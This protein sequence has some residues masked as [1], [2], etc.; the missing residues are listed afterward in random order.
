MSGSYS[1]YVQY[2]C[3]SVQTTSFVQLMK[4]ILE[5]FDVIDVGEE[6]F[7]IWEECLSVVGKDLIHHQL[8]EIP[9]VITSMEAYPMDLV[10]KYKSRLSDLFS[11]IER[12]DSLSFEPVE[13]YAAILQ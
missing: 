6:Y 11:E 2:I 13:V 8:Q 3:Q 4:F 1:L 12:L 7:Q 5:A 10:I 9:K